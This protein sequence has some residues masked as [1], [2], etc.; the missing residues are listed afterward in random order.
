MGDD[1]D[2]NAKSDTYQIAPVYY[3]SWWHHDEENH[4]K[5]VVE[6]LHDITDWKIFLVCHAI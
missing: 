4:I 2:W 5:M 6:Y 1:D 3:Q